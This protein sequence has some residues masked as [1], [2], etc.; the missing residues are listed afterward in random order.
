[1]DAT[2]IIEQ[3]K[4]DAIGYSARWQHTNPGGFRHVARIPF[5][6]WLELQSRGIVQGLRVVDERA[7]LRHISDPD[8]RKLRCDNGARLA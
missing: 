2:G 5:P 3:N 7:F 6:E 8:N 1:M 4:R